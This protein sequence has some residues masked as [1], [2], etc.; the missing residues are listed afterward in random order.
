MIAN[1]EMHSFKNSITY[2]KKTGSQI[3][4][5]KVKNLE[6]NYSLNCCIE[7]K[8]LS[9]TDLQISQ[10]LQKSSS[11]DSFIS[12]KLSNCPI[13]CSQGLNKILV[14]PFPNFRIEIASVL[15]WDTLPVEH[16][17][18]SSL[19]EFLVQS[20]DPWF[21]FASLLIQISFQWRNLRRFFFRSTKIHGRRVPNWDSQHNWAPRANTRDRFNELAQ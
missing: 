8:L 4:S 20:K 18:C 6:L 2:S 9:L 19:D 15:L 16:L 3:W 21:S 10:T 12:S 7:L 11:V 1:H 17:L 13:A 14:R 5:R